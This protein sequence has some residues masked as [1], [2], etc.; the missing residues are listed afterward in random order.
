MTIAEV[1]A[2]KKGIMLC[3]MLNVEK[4]RIHSNSLKAAG[5]IY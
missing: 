3:R 4:V 2:I 5:Y 1:L